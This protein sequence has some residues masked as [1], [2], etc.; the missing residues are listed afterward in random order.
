MPGRAKTRFLLATS[1]RSFHLAHTPPPDYPSQ[2]ISFRVNDGCQEEVVRIR[3]VVAQ[4]VD[5]DAA[6]TQCAGAGVPPAKAAHLLQALVDL[7]RELVRD[8]DA[9]TCQS[10]LEPGPDAAS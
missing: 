4:S 5:G 10:R 1:L 7:V 3:A 9:R 6:R 8:L 2:I